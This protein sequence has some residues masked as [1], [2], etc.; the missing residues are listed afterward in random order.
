ML[1]CY[2]ESKIYLLLFIDLELQY[3]LHTQVFYE[4]L[5]CYFSLRFKL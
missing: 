1:C 2:T 5:T 4:I 3:K